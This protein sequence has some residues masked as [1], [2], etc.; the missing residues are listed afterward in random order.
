MTRILPFGEWPSP[1]SARDVAAGSHAVDGARFVGDE[2]WWLE[3][4]PTEGGRTSVFRSRGGAPERLLPPPWNVRSRVHEYGGG[5][6]TT[7]RDG[8]LAFVEKS[9]QRVWLVRAGDDPVPL[10]PAGLGMR[11]GDL[12]AAGDGL[13]AVR[14]WH[15]GPGSPA[16]AIV[17]IPLDGRAAEDPDAIVAVAA[18]SD[19]V[20]YPSVSP[21]GDRLAWIAWDHP[22]MPWETTRLEV[23]DLVDGRAGP[24]RTLAGGEHESVLQPEWTGPDDLLAVSDASGWWNIVAFDLSAPDAR[25]MPVAPAE[26]ETGGPLW[27]LGARWYA[28]MPDGRILAVRTHGADELIVLDPDGDSAPIDGGPTSRVLVQDARGSTVLVTGAGPTVAGGLW[29]VD[30]DER[31]AR[32]IRSSVDEDLDTAWL[33]TPRSVTVTGPHGPVHAVV[34]PPAHPDVS[35]APDAA[36]P[37]LVLAHGGP[38]SH[39]SGEASPAVAYFTSRGI[40]ILDVNYG[41]STGFG[42]AYRERL[43]GRWGIVDRDDVVAAASGVA[44]AGIA[45]PARLAIRG[46]SA[47]G[48]TVLCALTATDRFA[49]G[50]SRYG[51]GDLRALAADTHDFEA[52]YL[53]GLVGPLPEAEA[54]YIERSPLSHL[55]RFT[56]PMLLEQGLDD[57]V[58]PPSQSEMV[59]DALAARGVVHAYLAFEGEGHGFRSAQTITRSLEAELSFLGQVLGFTPPGIPVLEL[60]T[61][62]RRD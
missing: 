6:W 14:E 54:V 42:R 8:A 52:R 31:R 28:P 62:R 48:W 61:S 3:R 41:G 35:G 37:Y 49:A 17:E 44:D 9:D 56:T 12:A 16:R 51:V 43:D 13:L 22:H 25:A 18:G 23:A 55:E 1:I 7:T 26:A 38:T 58:V 15:L 46:G 33:S 40:G 10:T 30:L 27:N 50:I 60:E 36:P 32:L 57:E 53:D 20:A 47:G 2:I 24:R 59:R 45:D 39:V 19:F 21:S 5:A 34:Y 29:A 4:I 11:F